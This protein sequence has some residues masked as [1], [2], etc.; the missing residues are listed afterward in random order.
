M[1]FKAEMLEKSVPE[2][3]KDEEYKMTEED[4]KYVQRM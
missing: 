2:E 4:N 3:A 1:R